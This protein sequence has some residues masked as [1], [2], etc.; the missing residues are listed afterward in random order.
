MPWVTIVIAL[1]MSFFLF[2]CTAFENPFAPVDGPIEMGAGLN[3]LLQHWAMLLHPPMLYLGFIG[4]T[5]PYAYAIA[6]MA[7]AGC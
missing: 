4:F 2:M 3:P 7:T 5:I 1:V 6:A